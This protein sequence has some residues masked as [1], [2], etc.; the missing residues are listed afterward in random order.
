M[1]VNR[2]NKLMSNAVCKQVDTLLKIIETGTPFL[3]QEL[4][5]SLHEFQ[6][7]ATAVAES[8]DCLRKSCDFCV[9]NSHI[10]HLMHTQYRI[11]FNSMCDNDAEEAKPIID[12][13]DCIIVY[14]E[15]YVPKY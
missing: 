7:F 5:A 13:L 4:S 1:I 2:L 6:E 3:P 11:I 14:L 8:C 9:Q 12:A 10:G 15:R